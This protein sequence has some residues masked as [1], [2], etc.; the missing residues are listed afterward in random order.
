MKETLKVIYVGLIFAGIFLVTIWCFKAY[1]SGEEAKVVHKETTEH[2]DNLSNTIKN[3]D[4][5]S[6]DLDIIKVDL[7]KL[8]ELQGTTTNT[9]KQ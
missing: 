2:I 3:L 4:T 6:T 9:L 8:I 1:K 5:I 7:D